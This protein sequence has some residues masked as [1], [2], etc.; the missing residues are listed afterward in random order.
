MP[1]AGASVLTVVLQAAARGEP[2]AAESLLPLVYEE[3]R[4]MAR[5]E[6]GRLKPGQTLQPTALVHEAYLRLVRAG[7]PGWEGRRHFYGAAARA[8]REI[9]IEQARRKASLKRGGPATPAQRVDAEHLAA[10]IEAP[11]DDMLALNEALQELSRIDPERHEIVMLRYFAGLT[12]EQTA[13][14]IGMSM[15]TTERQWRF[16]RAWMHM[17]LS[18]KAERGPGT[19]PESCGSL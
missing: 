16:A 11:V 2:Q 8:M 6:L 9:L 3:L 18:E 12:V 1:D 17:R 15:R 13:E 14:L 19:D 5:S 4:R 7:D 10:P